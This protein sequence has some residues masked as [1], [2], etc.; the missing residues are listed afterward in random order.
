MKA[1][2]LPRMSHKK[3]GHSVRFGS[4]KVRSIRSIRTTRFHSCVRGRGG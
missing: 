3:S 2:M 4:T 1:E